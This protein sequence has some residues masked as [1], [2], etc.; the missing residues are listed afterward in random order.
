MNATENKD[1]TNEAQPAVGRRS[2]LNTAA[3]A[4]AGLVAS[5]LFLPEVAQA[6]T[7]ALTFANIPGTGD[8][9]VLNF[10]LALEDL[11]ADLYVQALQR[12]TIGGK[13][14]L[15]TYIPGMNLNF[16]DP[17]VDYCYKY[18]L[19][20][21]NHRDFLRNALG[22]AAIPQYKYNF[23]MQSL[24]RKQV[25][26]L[27]YTAEAL[28]TAAYLGAIPSLSSLTYLQIAGAIQ[29]TE[30]RHTAVFAEILN[31]LYNEGL[32][33]APLTSQFGG[34]NNGIEVPIAPDTVLKTVS[35][36]IVT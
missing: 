33:V 21:A 30:A 8:V 4:A 11:E 15:G 10:A 14:K 3:I 20:E 22:S 2:L 29:G 7:P 36:Y 26:D 27:L 16:G 17:D 34:T 5:Q 31:I 24:S 1:Q 13:N 25:G 28:G 9:K 35:P 18:G 12:F 32:N 23:G 6:V 19:V